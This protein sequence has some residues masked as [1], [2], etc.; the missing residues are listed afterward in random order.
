[1]PVPIAHQ[2]VARE[3]LDARLA[4]I[5]AATFVPPRAGWVRAIRDALGLSAAALGERIGVSQQAV[6]AIERS[7]LVGT[8]KL[9]TLRR[10][11]DALDCDVAYVLVPRRPLRDTLEAAALERARR[12]VA[13]VDTTMRLEGQGLDSGELERSVAE[14]ASELIASGRVWR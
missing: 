8:I 9:E 13:A 2:R 3:R 4:G 11:A 7:E 12:D 14:H 1:M 6:N 5:D 10:V